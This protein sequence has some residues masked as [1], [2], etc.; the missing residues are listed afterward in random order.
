MSPLPKQIAQLSSQ[1]K[2]TLLVKLLQQKMRSTGTRGTAND[3]SVRDLVSL[4]GRF[5]VNVADLADQA[6]LDPSIRFDAGPAA[7]VP[8]PVTS[9]HIFLTGATGFLG[10]FLLHE[11]LQ[12]TQADIH[13]LVRSA[14]AMEG[15]RRILDNLAAYLPGN[16]HDSSRILP[17]AGDLTQPLLG[18][19]RSQFDEL[20]GQVEVIYHDAALV[21]WIYPYS[22]L[23]PTNV[24]GTQEILRL[25]GRVKVKPLHYVSSLSVFPFV[26]NAERRVVREQDSLDHG[27]PLYGGYTQSKWVAE[28]VVTIAR[29]RGLPVTVYRPGLIIGHS[30]SGA[31]NTSDVTSRMLKSWI[32]LGAA[33]DVEATIDMTPVDYV[34]RAI[35]RLSR[36]DDTLGRIYH[37]AN[38]RPVSAQEL[39]VWIRALGYRLQAIPY[40]TWRKEMSS[41]ERHSPETALYSLGPLFTLEV[42]EETSW[43]GTIPEF[44]CQNTLA[45][46]ADTSIACPPVDADTFAT[47]FDYFVRSGFLDPPPLKGTPEPS[48]DARV[49][50]DNRYR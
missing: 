24:L 33:P 30:R 6:V 46:L 9:K 8:S 22:R 34:S 40:D 44:N 43:V 32:E 29:E 25:A 18:L 47:Y 50:A 38:P 2:R 5:A 16:V 36:L 27:E 15:K 13:C 49:A 3:L 4:I 19:A 17:V 41:H 23:K 35:V 31:W 48:S 10:A 37:L 39:I 20:A 11:L 14:T 1:E 45:R 42:A 26:A 28:K 21:N 12:H 7:P